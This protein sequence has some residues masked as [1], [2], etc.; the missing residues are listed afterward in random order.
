MTSRFIQSWHKGWVVLHLGREQGS[1]EQSAMGCWGT[2]LSQEGTSPPTF[3]YGTCFTGLDAQIEHD[4]NLQHRPETDWNFICTAQMCY[5][6]P[7]TYACMHKYF[8]SSIWVQF[9]ESPWKSDTRT[10]WSA[11]LDYIA[12]RG[13]RTFPLAADP[14]NSLC[15]HSLSQATASDSTHWDKLLENLQNVFQSSHK[16]AVPQANYGS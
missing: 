3:C 2:R 15:R 1:A 8:A 14:N 7:Y 10:S 12:C 16:Q 13:R 5:C 6:V 9:L 4:T 11:C